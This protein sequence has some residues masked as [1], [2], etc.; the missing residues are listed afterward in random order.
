MWFDI[1]CVVF[2]RTGYHPIRSYVTLNTGL[3]CSAAGDSGSVPKEISR[4]T[5]DVPSCF[6]SKLH[7]GFF[8]GAFLVL[9]HTLETR[10]L[11]YKKSSSFVSFG[12]FFVHRIVHRHS[13]IPE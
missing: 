8:I 9:Q 3:R 12:C 5:S 4:Y 10:P 11:P 6:D 13:V 1:L 2:V 7:D